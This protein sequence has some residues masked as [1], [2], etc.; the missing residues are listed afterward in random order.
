MCIEMS[1]WNLLTTY[2]SCITI[3]N[4][5]VFEKATMAAEN[6]HTVLS[7]VSYA[8]KYHLILMTSGWDPRCHAHFI[9]D[10]SEALRGYTP[11]RKT[12]EAD[13]GASWH[14]P[15]QRIL[16]V[17]GKKEQVLAT[18]GQ[19]E[20]G[21]LLLFLLLRA[22]EPWGCFKS[23]EGMTGVFGRNHWTDSSG[24]CHL[25]IL[26]RVTFKLPAR[27]TGFLKW[28]LTVQSHYK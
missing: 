12:V 8:P 21:T 2:N 3:A 16:T 26:A 17:A 28:F 22:P 1:H 11:F 5:S 24:S 15:F 20:S 23:S 27:V 7:V 19:D 10:G 9:N 18:E 14:C 25:D 6:T 13:H 4:E